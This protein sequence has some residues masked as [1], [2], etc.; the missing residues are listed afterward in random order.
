MLEAILRL[1]RDK[2]E[3][4]RFLQIASATSFIHKPSSEMPKPAF[5]K[6]EVKSWQKQN[7][8]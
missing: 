2:K 4:K 3:I 8:I 7:L 1:T 5:E 6:L